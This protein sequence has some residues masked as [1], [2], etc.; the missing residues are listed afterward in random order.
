MAHEMTSASS[1][2]NTRDDPP[3]NNT[4]ASALVNAA[5]TDTSTISRCDPAS[6]SHKAPMTSFIEPVST[7]SSR[8]DC[9]GDVYLQPQQQPHTHSHT[10][11]SG[12][13]SL[14]V[15]NTV[16]RRT[17]RHTPG[18]RTAGLGGGGRWRRVQA[19]HYLVVQVHPHDLCPA[20]A[21]VTSWTQQAGLW[22]R[23][24]S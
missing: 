16:Q 12:R 15:C 11:R 3:S 4:L 20:V 18:W 24:V 13:G 21:V 1:T 19:G 22:G 23:A 17:L 14:Q 10:L 6:S 7:A 2:V 9:R 8:C 5:S